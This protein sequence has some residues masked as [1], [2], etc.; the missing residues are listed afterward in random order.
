MRNTKN[1]SL[2]VVLSMVLVCILTCSLSTTFAAGGGVVTVNSTFAMTAPTG[3]CKLVAG[4]EV[5]VLGNLTFARF[6]D[7][8]VT[9]NDGTVTL[10]SILIEITIQ[11][12]NP[13][14]APHFLVQG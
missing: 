3:Y 10:P 1:L 12:T 9:P 14:P 11:G 2:R 4:S 13:W 6:W 8:S 5:V 7:T